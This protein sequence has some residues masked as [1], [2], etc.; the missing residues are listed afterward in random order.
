MEERSG[1]EESLGRLA[2]TPHD[3]VFAKFEEIH[4]R[5]TR[6]LRSQLPG[7]FRLRDAALSDGAFQRGHEAGPHTEIL[8]FTA[9]ETEIF[10]GVAGRVGNIAFHD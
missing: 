1:V 5:S 8:R 3:I 9:L 6:S 4:P 10:K 7:C 2:E